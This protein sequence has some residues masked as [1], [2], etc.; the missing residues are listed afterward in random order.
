MVVCTKS[1]EATQAYAETLMKEHPEHKVWLLEGELAAGKT[2]LVKGLAKALG[3]DSPIT[4]PT[5]AY[6]NE[7]GDK[8]AHYDLY[9]L[10][11]PDD[12]LL[13][14]LLE[15]MQTKEYVVVEW[16]SRM[17]LQLSRPHLK[18]NMYHKGGDERCIDVSL[19][20]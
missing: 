9:R 7:Y 12:E 8:L 16:P 1:A 17:N 19:P 3:V 11:G 15:H 6:V 10:E 5:F 20:S 14:L 2:Q 13:Q 18:I 4:S